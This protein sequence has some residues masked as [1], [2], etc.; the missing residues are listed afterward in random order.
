MAK[1]RKSVASAVS[2]VGITIIQLS[3]AYAQFVNIP[4]P[5]RFNNLEEIINTAGNLIRTAMV[6]TFLG[7][8]MYGGWVRMTAREDA[9]KVE[10]SSKIIVA[11]AIGFGIIVLAPVVVDLVGTLLGVQ[12]GLLDF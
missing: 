4:N 7:V 5:S 10:A 11:G 6:L 3:A 1:I 8:V 12:G 2:A 9:K